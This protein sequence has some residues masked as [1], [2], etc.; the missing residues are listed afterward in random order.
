MSKTFIKLNNNDYHLSIGNLFRIIKEMSSNKTAAL[1][2]ELFCILFNVKDINDTTVNNYCVGARSIGDAYKQIFINKEKEYAKDSNAFTEIIINIL[3]VIDG[4]IYLNITDKID[5]INNNKS[6]VNLCN[7]LY[8]L[9]KNDKQ[10][11]IDFIKKINNYIKSSKY[12]NALSELL[13]YIVLAKKQP[14]YEEDLKKEVIENILNDTSISA[15]SLQEYLSIKLREGINY[16]YSMKK[17]ASSGNAYAN[18]E[19]GTDEYYGHQTGYPR[20]SKALDYLKVAA[21]LN[22]AS[23]NYIV[24]RIYVEGLIGNKSKEDLIKGYNYLIKADQLGNIA[25]AN[26]IGNMYLKGILP[27]KKNVSKAIEYYKKASD[28]NYVYAFNNLGTIAENNKEIKKAYEYYQKS[29][30]LGESWACNKI[31]L[32]YKKNNN[33]KKAYDYFNKA[34]DTN[35]HTLYYYAYYNLAKYFYL[36]GNQGVEKNI[37]KAKEY[38]NIASDHNIFEALIELFYIYIKEYKDIKDKELY[39]KIIDIKKRIEQHEKYNNDIKEHI[40]DNLKSIK[41]NKEIDI[42]WLKEENN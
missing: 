22:H 33:I 21:E 20:Y 39:N 32:Y 35:Y 4:K 27:C 41:N 42:S 17:L 26:L 9:A 36:N 25:A 11:S 1:Q 29:A 37:K 16:D 2:S 38:F 23:A 10:V 6:I 13:I 5:F 3:N 8:N 34:I 14:I 31:G 7:N 40:E 12:Y 24:G 19:L 18:Y 15:S 30:D 28:A